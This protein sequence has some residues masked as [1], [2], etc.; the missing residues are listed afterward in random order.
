MIISR[1]KQSYCHISVI[2]I[3]VNNYKRLY[4]DVDNYKLMISKFISCVSLCIYVSLALSIYY[5]VWNRISIYLSISL[6]IYYDVWNS[7]SMYL[8]IYFYLYINTNIDRCKRYKHEEKRLKAMDGG[9]NNH[10]G[11]K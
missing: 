3:D 9:L 5:D 4:C 1:W 6:S 10:I 7:L 2:S 11:S 8:C